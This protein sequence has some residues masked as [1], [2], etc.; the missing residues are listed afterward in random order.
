M[1]QDIYREAIQ[2]SLCPFACH[3]A[4]YDDNNRMIDC[5]FLDV[6]P[7]FEALTGWKK[8]D[9]I[10]Q[11]FVQTLTR[12]PMNAQKWVRHYEV[13]LR[14]Q[15]PIEFEDYSSE[16]RQHFAV[17]AFPA[18]DQC[19]ITL[20]QTLTFEKKM[21]EIAQYLIANKGQTVD[22]EKLAAF[23]VDVTGAEYAALNLFESNGRDFTTVAMYGN[24]KVIQQTLKKLDIKIIGRKWAYDRA[25]EER[26]RDNILTEIDSLHDL[27]GETLPMDMIT[28]LVSQ[29][30]LG[31]VII[32]KITKLDQTLGDL[33]LLF[34]KGHSLHNRELFQLYL[35]QLGLFI[36]KTGL[37][38]S[39][40]ASQKQF[41]TLAQYA[42]I[43]F[44]SCNIQGDILF[45]NQ[46][47]LE[48]LDSPSSE[49][50]RR[51]N[52]FE[53]PELQKT[54]F[55]DQLKKCMAKSRDLT[56]EMGYTSVWGRSRWLRVHF[57]PI[58]ENQTVVGASI[59]IDDVSDKKE[60]EDA[61]RKKMQ[62]D[63]LTKAY[64]RNVLETVLSDRLNEAIDQKLIGCLAVVDIDDFKTIN[65][66]HGHI[67]GDKVLT[68]LASR[69]KKELHKQDL[70]IRTGGDEFLIYLHDVNHEANAV[71]AIERIYRKI[72]ADYRMND[73]ISGHAYTLTVRCSMGGQFFAQTRHHHRCA[74]GT[75]G[76]RAL[77]GEKPGQGQLLR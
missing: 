21:Q 20:F 3:K 63:P 43:G 69:V 51:I 11:R 26:I 10:N 30:D 14:D 56:Y 67:A 42:P 8:D 66:Q 4:V 6:N 46:R 24:S 54:D 44:I 28:Q 77:P 37:E 71:R 76:S 47:V 31:P 16:F 59:V 52:L 74:A 18:G 27:V 23:A 5:I 73:S 65:D 68:Y 57:T 39:L 29:L 34:R 12:D 22:Y 35:S 36:E 49:A 41:Y 25:R 75:G 62:R 19:F 48:I 17:K 32:A 70:I 9:I 13:V 33:T 38:K 60:N 15:A 40:S 50:T 45:A 72:S 7:A 61:L 2:S 58:V 64:N 1:G 55:P 53:L